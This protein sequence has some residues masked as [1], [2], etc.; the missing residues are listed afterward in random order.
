MFNLWLQPGSGRSYQKYPAPGLL[1]GLLQ[2]DV[3][4]ISIIAG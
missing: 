3:L 1:R 4:V 2:Q